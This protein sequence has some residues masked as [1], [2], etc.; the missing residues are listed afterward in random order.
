MAECLICTA[1]GV[2]VAA[3]YAEAG[4]SLYGTVNVRVLGGMPG[5][6]SWLPVSPKKLSAE[7][8]I[9]R[10]KQLWFSDV[11]VER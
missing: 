4:G 9:K 11:T 3:L 6:A 1:C 5:F 8:K 10:W 2:Y 7:D